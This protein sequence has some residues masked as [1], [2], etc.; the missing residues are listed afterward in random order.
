[1]F[2]VQQ[3][4]WYG[5]EGK[6]LALFILDRD[7][8]GLLNDTI[9]VNGKKVQNPLNQE[10]VTIRAVVPGEYIVNVHYYATKTNNPVDVN[11]KVEKVNPQLEVIYYGTIN[12][13]KKGVEKTATRFNITQGGSVSVSGNLY[14]KLVPDN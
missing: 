4:I 3:E 5:L 2:K 1:M 6:K 12:L 7:D 13:E 9:E 10:V 11:V 8:R 14:K